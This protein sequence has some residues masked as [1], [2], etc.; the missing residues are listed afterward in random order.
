[1][2]ETAKVIDAR[3]VGE[4]FVEWGLV[5][6]QELE[7]A[8]RRQA[9]T[10][11]PLGEILVAHYGV[12]RLQL[13]SALAEQWA[14]AG[15]APWSRPADP[16]AP[17]AA[18]A[19]DREEQASEAAVQEGVRRRIG[20]IFVERGLISDAELSRALTI[21]RTNGRRLGEVLVEH[22]AVTRLDLAGA[23]ADHWASMPAPVGDRS[24]SMEPP[25]GAGSRSAA[26]SGQDSEEIRSLRHS[27]H[28]LAG[29]L[30]GAEQKAGLSTHGRDDEI[31]PMAMG[32][33]IDDIEARL[34]RIEALLVAGPTVI[35]G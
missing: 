28:L 31:E 14:V 7:S 18:P 11:G 21:Q 10:G 13:A 22:G 15:Q 35:S 17:S 2:S 16:V 8:L 1:V 27:L 34:R 19:R 3:L 32:S 30:A 29:R 4:I 9:R 25:A 26:P 24:A 12:S 20:E 5:L 6:E 23:L 33:R